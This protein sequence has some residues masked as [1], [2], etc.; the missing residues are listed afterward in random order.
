MDILKSIILKE[1]K[2]LKMNYEIGKLSLLILF[3]DLHACHYHGLMPT[4]Q[5][6]EQY[7]DH[8]HLKASCK[9]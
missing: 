7:I 1:T 5:I 2:I 6:F 8:S 4:L 3:Q 9:L